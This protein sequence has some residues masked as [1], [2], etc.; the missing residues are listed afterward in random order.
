VR[1]DVGDLHGGRDG[2]T[3]RPASPEKPVPLAHLDRAVRARLRVERIAR[4]FSSLIP[5]QKR[6]DV[7]GNPSP[8][9]KIALRPHAALS[10]KSFM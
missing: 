7:R 2:E 4:A 10:M 6:K 3:I 9:L 5:P 8:L 1:D